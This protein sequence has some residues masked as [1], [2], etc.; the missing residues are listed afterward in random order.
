MKDNFS[1][2]NKKVFVS[3]ATRGIG[4]AIAFLFKEKKAFV[5]GTGRKIG[6]V[7]PWLDEYWALDFENNEDILTCQ[8]K[9][10]AFK[11]DILIN[12]A[13]INKISSFEEI[14]AEDFARIQQVN[15]FAPF[16]IMKA[17]L[18]MMKE[19]AWGRI[20]N[21]SSIWG[22]ISKSHR[23]SYSASKFALDGMTLAVALEYAQ[24]GIIA[25]CV[26]PGFTDTE[27]T[28]KVLGADNIKELTNLVPIKRMASVDEIAKFVLW[29]ASPENTYINGQNIAIDGGFT[30]G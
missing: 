13:G 8:N 28:R 21:I 29:L 12:N 23:G 16:M 17:S 24:F 7:V 4:K 18:P 9:I 5:V 26:A 3:G 6:E 27:L 25:N 11:P 19:N 1:L 22:K 14:T 30:R 2:E 10:R 15:V 20:V